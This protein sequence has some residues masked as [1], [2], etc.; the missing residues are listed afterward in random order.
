MKKIHPSI[1]IH[2]TAIIDEGAAL[3]KDCKIWHWTHI[4]SG[5]KIGNNCSLG[6]NVFIANNVTIGNNVKIQNNVSIYDNVILEDNV[7]CGPSVVFT[8]VINPRSAFSRKHEYKK[9]IIKKGASLGANSTLVCGVTIG[10]HSFIGAGAVITK[11]VK[12]YGLYTGVPGK[13]VGWISAY[14]EKVDLPL[15][16]DDSWFCKRT[17]TLYKLKESILISIPN[18]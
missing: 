2:P 4:S 7:F 17:N 15:R 3:G 8:N 5:A 1:L 13:H 11:N 18:K 16:G 12:A 10:E 6:Q 9:T 14:G